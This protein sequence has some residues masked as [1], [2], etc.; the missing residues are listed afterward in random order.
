[1]PKQG[2]R[3]NGDPAT[4][5]HRDRPQAVDEHTEDLH[6]VLSVSISPSPS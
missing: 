6:R 5:L 1:M 2:N 3:V 4:D